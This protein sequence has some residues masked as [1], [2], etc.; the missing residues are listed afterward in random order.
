[1][2]MSKMFKPDISPSKF[3]FPCNISLFSQTLQV[4]FSLLSQIMGLQDDKLVTEIMVGTMCLVIQS[5]KEFDLSFDEYLVDKISYQLE[6]FNSDGKVFNCQT[7]LM[8][9]VIT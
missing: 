3:S 8:L 9:I 1:M 7:L 5:T 2:F 4:V 6:H